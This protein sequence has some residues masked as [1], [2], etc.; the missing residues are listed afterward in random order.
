MD[1]S[2]T[3]GAGHWRKPHRSWTMAI[4]TN[5]T[6]SFPGEGPTLSSE[7]RELALA[8]LVKK[9]SVALRQQPAVGLARSYAPRRGRF[10]AGRRTGSRWEGN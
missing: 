5:S 1:A 3:L 6:R 10:E 8:A 7:S 9:V 4:V 2:D